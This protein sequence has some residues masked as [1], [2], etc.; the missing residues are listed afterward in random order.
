MRAIS[1]CLALCVAL[2]WG[3]LF[4]ESAGASERADHERCLQSISQL[5]V[6]PG[7]DI[8]RWE[9]WAG[10]AVSPR[11][12]ATWMV[13]GRHAGR[14]GLFVYPED[15]DAS[16]FPEPT[17]HE[18]RTF[19]FK[20]EL[21]LPGRYPFRCET[22]SRAG[23]W[24]DVRK[25]IYRKGTQC[26]TFNEH[27]PSGTYRVVRPTP[28]RPPA[29]PTAAL[30][31]AVSLRISSMSETYRREV[32]RYRDELESYVRARRRIRMAGTMESIAG[33]FGYS[34]R[35][36]S[37]PDSS[38]WLRALSGCVPTEEETLRTQVRTMRAIIEHQ[39]LPTLAS[40]EA[41]ADQECWESCP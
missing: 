6:G 23:S 4:C 15:G 20:Y 22:Q 39:P 31:T 1:R 29:D 34:P 26:W 30:R 37:P 14:N 24:E 40:I 41:Q 21:R 35:L 17:D 2:T 11:A 19:G 36:P 10:D 16:F 12:R 25:K 9:Q 8:G 27:A 3:S 18:T 38:A 28:I 7:D 5:S 13:P 32:R 33:H